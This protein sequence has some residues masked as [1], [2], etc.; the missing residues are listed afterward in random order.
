MC[1]NY[2]IISSCRIDEQWWITLCEKHVSVYIIKWLYILERP[3]SVCD[4]SAFQVFGLYK[5]IDVFKQ[6]FHNIVDGRFS[7]VSVE[8]GST[9]ICRQLWTKFHFETCR[10]SL[11]DAGLILVYQ[12]RCYPASQEY[13]FMIVYLKTCC[14]VKG[15]LPSVQVERAGPDSSAQSCSRHAHWQQPTRDSQLGHGLPRN[16]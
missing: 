8:Q 7:W 16:A 1:T 5:N 6:G 12:V 15:S 3:K 13:C 11:S 14:T 2:I 9:V 4:I 10:L